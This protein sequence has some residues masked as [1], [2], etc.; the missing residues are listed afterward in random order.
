MT[1]RQN[2]DYDEHDPYSIER[3]AQRLIGKTFAQVIKDDVEPIVSDVEQEYTVS[4][5]NKRQ[6]G[7]LGT[8][9]EERFFHY[10]ANS[11]Q[12]ADFY[13]AGVELK[14]TPY[15]INPDGKKVAKERLII[16]MID[17]NKVVQET[18]YTSHVWEKTKR[19]LLIYYCFKQ[20]VCTKLD[21][22][23]DYARLFSPS[24]HDEK[25]IRHDYEKIIE[26]IREGKAHE[27]S[28]SDTLYL[29]AATKSSSSEIRRTQ[30]FS[31]VLAKPR[32]FAF[33][34]TYMTFVLNNYIIPGRPQYESIL[35][36]DETDDFEAY[37]TRKLS[38]YKGM[39]IS[40]LCEELEVTYSKRPKNLESM[41]AFRMLGIRGNN[42]EEFVKAGIKVKSIRVQKN[43]K[44]K[45]NM[46]FPTFKFTD[47][48]EQ[49]WETS[50]LREYLDE[51]RFLFV[52]YGT[53]C[54][55]ELYFK[56]VMFWNIPYEDL[57][58]DVRTVWSMTQKAITDGLIIEEIKGIHYSN[59]P[60]QSENPV[61][62]V[63]P[64]GQNASDTC[65][66]P[67]GRKFPKQSFWLNNTY[68]EE[69][70]KTLD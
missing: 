14:V 51:T 5:E 22:K 12:H 10:A 6:K 47:I 40:E 4:V 9:I 68:I 49:T 28:E 21:Y 42:A 50:D 45:E 18:F 38:S 25:I 58:G 56:G 43:G 29:G 34:T 13:E 1:D 57:E 24:P 32:A 39:T 52:I 59:L 55:D 11:D 48:A 15:R 19:I 35:G 16:T 44:I 2:K 8:L 36:A 53:N 33:K 26:K 7:G 60:K 23:I 54:T 31:M 46:S 66:L 69:Q 30:P 70:I 3:Y 27:L 62:H 64:H 67:D 17:Y 61:C 41:L 65:E 20:D 37:V 63:R